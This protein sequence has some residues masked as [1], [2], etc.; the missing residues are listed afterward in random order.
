VLWAKSS[1]VDE[2][3][4]EGHSYFQAMNQCSDVIFLVPSDKIITKNSL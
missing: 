3:K 2:G 1:E 4:P